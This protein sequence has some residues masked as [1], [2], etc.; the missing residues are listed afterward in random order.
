MRVFTAVL[1]AAASALFLHS[2]DAAPVDYP[3][4]LVQAKAMVAKMSID[5]LLGQMNQIEVEPITSED[6]TNGYTR[7]VNKTRVATLANLSVGSYL[8]LIP[9]LAEFG[10]P[11]WSAAQYRKMVGELQAIHMNSSTPIPILYG[12][13][14]IHGANF[15][16]NSTLFPHAINTGAT[17]NPAYAG[18]VGTYTARDTLA[19]GM[20]WVFGPILDIVRHKHWPRMY[21]SFG[22]DPTMVAAMG[23][24]YI[25]GMQAQGVAACFKH[26]IGY[27]DPADGNDRTDAVFSTYEMLNYFAKPFQAAIDDAQVLSGMGTYVGWNG[28]PMAANSKTSRDLLR[29]DMNF[30]GLMVTDWGE[31]YLL[32]SPRHIVA[33]DLDAIDVSMNKT[34][35]DMVMTPEDTSFIDHGHTLLGMN[36]LAR[37]R[38]EE[39]VTRILALK[40]TLDLFNNPVPGA[41]LVPLVGDALSQSRA[42]AVARDSLVL[43]KNTNNTLPLDRPTNDTTIFLTG[44]SADNIGFLCGGWSLAWQGI[45]DST[46]FP[47]GASIRDALQGR[48]EANNATKNGTLTFLEGVNIRGNVTNASLATALTYAAAAEFTVVVLGE[49]TYA[50]KFGNADPMALPDRMTGYVKQLAATGTK[51]ILVLVEGRPRLLDG[52]AEIAHAVLWA[53]LP[54]EFGGE[55]ITDVLFGKVNPSGKLP[56]TYPKTDAFVNLATPYYFRQ[57]QTCMKGGVAADCPTEFAYGAGLSY[58]TF[59][60]S[61]MQ[62]SASSIKAP[63]A[64]VTVSVTVTNTGTRAGKESVLLFVTPP[65]THNLSETRLLKKFTKLSLNASESKVVQFTLTP[66][67]W[68]FFDNEI[69]RGFHKA[70]P[71]GSYV[72]FF[73]PTTDCN[74]QPM[75]C[76]DFKWDNGIKASPATSVHRRWSQAWL[77]AVVVVVALS[78]L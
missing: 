72:V 64:V 60:Y 48:F 37:A 77:A 3:T 6:W 58:T 26:F 45:T 47:H 42:L 70:A 39:S 21:E 1:G 32:T 7:L 74:T 15:I 12:F 20:P 30:T 9:A 4:A 13:D 41:D 33:S 31:I 29:H 5:Q 59:D 57:G 67:D 22:E 53:G 50:E 78:L 66:D 76:R 63:A 14:S 46:M 43:L 8:N 52:L 11:I 34:S 16:A 38:L 56:F 18:E 35:Y 65:R 69:G 55:A 54:C 75:L 71:S 19:G 27:S 2:A 49:R 10:R 44:P 36:R 51:I 17:F 68:G 40:L 25:K 28:V 24:S 61:N 23:K 62:I 73:K